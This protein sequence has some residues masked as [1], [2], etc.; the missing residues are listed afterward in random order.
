MAGLYRNLG[1]EAGVLEVA[2]QS[3]EDYELCYYNYLFMLFEIS[4]ISL[5]II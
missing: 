3:V 2:K 4:R 5:A 1:F